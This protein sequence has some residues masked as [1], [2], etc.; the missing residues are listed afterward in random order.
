M[1]VWDVATWAALV[2]LGPGSIVIFIAFLRDLRRLFPRAEGD[3][4]EGD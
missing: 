1:S 3:R 4:R 2:I